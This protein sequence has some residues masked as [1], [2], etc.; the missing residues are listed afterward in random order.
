M[1]DNIVNGYEIPKQQ[2]N[3]INPA[4]QVQGQAVSAVNPNAVDTTPKADTFANQTSAATNPAA[5]NAVNPNEK[6]ENSLVKPAIFLATFYGLNK[7]DG[8]FNK[9]CG[10]EYDKTVLAKLGRFGDKVS[11]KFGNSK[12]IDAT[13]GVW[14]AFKIKAMKFIDS[15]PM[16]SAM[17]HTPTKPENGQVLSFLQ[18]QD[19]YDLEQA[20]KHIKDFINNTP[21]SLKEAG[22]T[23]DEIKALKAQYGTNIFGQIKSKSR[24]IEEFQ[25]SKIR[26]DLV[27]KVKPERL[28]T[29][30]RYAKMH[31]LGVNS[32]NYESILADS[33]ANKDVI[34]KA[35]ETKASPKI[36]ES[37]NKL[38]SSSM[39]ATKLGKLL[40]KASK[41]F[42]RG[43][44]FGG[45]V[46]NSLFI[47]WGL[48]TALYNAYKAPKKQKVGTA[49]AGGVDAVSWV[50]SMPI[51][52]KMMHGVNGIKNTGLSKDE[53]QTYRD[54]L[55]DFNKKAS[56]G[57]FKDEA[58]HASELKKVM[59]LKNVKVPQGKFT[60][61]MKKVANVLS[62][63]LEMP[64]PFR[65]DT[66]TLTGAAKRA[67]RFGNIKRMI[68]NILKD[69][70]G[71]P[72]RFLIYFAVA[73]PI[74]DKVIS[75][76]TNTFFGKPY[77]PDKAAEDAAKRAAKA[78]ERKYPPLQ[79]FIIPDEMKGRIKSDIAIDSLPDANLIKQK[80]IGG[81]KSTYIPSDKPGV[82]A[83]PYDIA[84]R[85]YIPQ[86]A[87]A[88]IPA[89]IEGKNPD[90]DSAIARADK[91]EQ[92]AMQALNG[93]FS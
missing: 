79:R 59:D 40:P 87:A 48:G 75:S 73:Q 8:L 65:V 12:A 7:A 42:M 84:A 72:L 46:F 67:A 49:V 14:G 39:H 86:E 89:N 47:A 58:E 77:D 20:S 61:F 54:S 52:L 69:C 44:T 92:K 60:K 5:P 1:A 66:S 19:E 70:A 11:N 3:N 36:I 35:C 71:Y 62:V 28:S 32:H 26:P 24:A 29:F 25:L 81:G 57:L 64:K 91:V 43:L 17:A 56:A 31:H 78:S 85:T 10:G 34:I 80:V 30:L 76:I 82:P 9:A 50:V 90:V 88:N 93:N 51:A 38:I 27:G 33:A 4:P 37:F 63:S 53:V 13:R 22:A 68:P 74:V 45:G 23:K 41:L 16:L 83:N 18:S 6:K 2:Q 21:K 55:K 15:K